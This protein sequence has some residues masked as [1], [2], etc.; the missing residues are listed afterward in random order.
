MCKVA[1][2]AKLGVKG[3]NHQLRDIINK[4]LKIQ[5]EPVFLATIWVYFVFVPPRQTEEMCNFGLPCKPTNN[6]RLLITHQ[7]EPGQ[8]RYI[9][10]FLELRLSIV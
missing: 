4:I 1:T 6:G 3:G 2:S 10:I 5:C 7:A 8:N 9:V